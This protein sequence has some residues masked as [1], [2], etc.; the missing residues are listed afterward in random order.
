MGHHYVPQR[1]LQNFQ[2]R[3]GLV[4]QHDK[5]TGEIREVAI[6]QAAQSKGYYADDIEK[7]L[8]DAVEGP[9]NP[10]M[11]K[12]LK[13]EPLT[14]DE[15]HQMALYIGAMLLRGP[16]SRRKMS[17]AFPKHVATYAKETRRE[18]EAAA[19][20]YADVTPEFL[21]R[22]LAQLDE[23]ER[24]FAANPSPEMV[25]QM[26]TPIP[27]ANM[28]EAI[29][30]MTWRIMTPKGNE[31]FITTDSPAFYFDSLG[32][33]TQEAEVSFPLSTTCAL[34]GSWQ[35]AASL[36]VYVD[37][38]DGFVMEVN[39]RGASGAARFGYYH[40]TA[41]WL[42]T[43]LTKPK[44]YLSRLWFSKRPVWR[45]PPSIEPSGKRYF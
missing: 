32:L 37:V 16:A 36:L 9:A 19:A 10:V 20:K 11:E 40:K 6:K 15:R 13:K 22:V 24:N 2:S 27:Y 12:L 39:R 23:W 33:G 18:I 5:Q 30:L 28:V 25:E 8:A 7:L 17:A 1:Y 43:L 38:G 44:P 31:R 29:E 14:P 3:T 42:I 41:D 34:H 35:A 4:W 21:A 26:E 45:E